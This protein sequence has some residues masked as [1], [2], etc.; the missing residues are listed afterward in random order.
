MSDALLQSLL[1]RS[2]VSPDAGAIHDV[3]NT[4][5]IGTK[6]ASDR[7]GDLSRAAGS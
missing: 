5:D 3:L 6:P 1:Q 4:F 2:Q 7:F